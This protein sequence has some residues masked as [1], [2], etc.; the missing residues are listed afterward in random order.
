MCLKT[1]I[2]RNSV[3]SLFL[4]L[5]GCAS[6]YTRIAPQTIKSYNPTPSEIEGLEFSYRYDVL[7]GRG[8]KRYAKKEQKNATS[9]VAIRI[10]NNTS[11]ELTLGDNIDLYRNSEKV[12]LLPKTYVFTSLRQ[13]EA[14]YFLYLLLTPFTFTVNNEPVIKA[15]LFGFI[16]ATP[17]IIF[18]VSKVARSNGKFKK[19][20]EMYS[21]ENKTIPPQDTLY[22]LIGIKSGWDDIK[23]LNLKLKQ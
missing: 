2:K 16:V 12:E 5:S 1:I 14:G 20:L 8:N 9:L 6:S 3:I 23:T 15:P 19:E 22:G 10:I 11:T 17:I 13:K 21:I 18:N 4:V 7:A